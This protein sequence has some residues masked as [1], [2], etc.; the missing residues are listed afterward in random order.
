MTGHYEGYW[1]FYPSMDSEVIRQGARVEAAITPPWLVVDGSITS[2]IVTARK[3]PGELWRV[4]V[5]E[6]G[7]MSGLI[8]EPG[9]RRAKV[10]E[11]VEQLPL[12]DLFGAHGD[13][14]L[15]ILDRV[16]RLSA[17]EA[18]TLAQA[19][20]SGG[21]EAY[22]RGWS[23]W[24]DMPDGD[25]TGVIAAPGRNGQMRSPVHGGLSLA[26]DLLQ[27]RARALE[28]E[29]AFHLVPDDENPSEHMEV[30]VPKWEGA[31]DAVM[32]AVMAMGAPEVLEAHDR[33]AL[34]QAWRTVALD[35]L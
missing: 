34:L 17:S 21:W 19:R 13:A 28:G 11:L 8:A 35:L 31:S 3:W 15:G 14:V 20:S 5:V 9:Y 22:G 18:E 30:L 2:I 23:R 6:P 29:A 32:Q 12:A 27:S 24:A 1:Y 26:T 33:E 10:I 4:R 7:D 16:V 25:W